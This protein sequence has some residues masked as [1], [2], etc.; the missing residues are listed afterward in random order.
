[1]YIYLNTN[2]VRQDWEE[3][4]DGGRRGNISPALFPS[5]G[6]RCILGGSSWCFVP[7]LCS[8]A[9]AI[10]VFS[11]APVVA[12]FPMQLCSPAVAIWVFS[13]ASSN[14]HINAAVDVQRWC[15]VPQLCSPVVYH[16]LQLMHCSP[17]LFPSSGQN[18]YSWGL[19]LLIIII[20][21]LIIFIIIGG[22][23]GG[24]QGVTEI[25]L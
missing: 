7:Q 1:M 3:D 18:G 14:T 13:G 9:V 19:Q 5:S 4:Y 21:S 11:G 10:W 2:V 16:G 6:H 25:P 20:T 8:P 12:L 24:G 17:A 15:C 22:R 23:L